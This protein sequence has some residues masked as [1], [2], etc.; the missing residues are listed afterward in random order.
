MCLACKR[1]RGWFSRNNLA[2]A[3]YG[4]ATFTV[5]ALIFAI[6]QPRYSDYEKHLDN[7]VAY[8]NLAFIASRYIDLITSQAKGGKLQSVIQTDFQTCLRSIEAIPL[9]EVYPPYFTQNF[10]DLWNVTKQTEDLTKESPDSE[11]V[12]Q[13]DILN[14]RAKRD[15]SAIDRYLKSKNIKF[16]EDN[17][18]YTE[19]SKSWL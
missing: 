3:A 16:N 6:Y 2:I 8:R 4:Q 13:L 10:A 15:I 14:D 7:L 18:A 5:L 17:M 11:G 9:N 1:I 12:K 19:A